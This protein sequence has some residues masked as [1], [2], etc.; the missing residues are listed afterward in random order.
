[1]QVF[2]LVMETKMIHHCNCKDYNGGQC[3]N[4][5]NGAHEFCSAKKICRNKNSK[6]LGLPIVIKQRPMKK[7]II[8]IAITAV[9]FA[10][11]KNTPTTNSSSSSST[12]KTK[13]TYSYQWKSMGNGNIY[14]STEC[15]NDSMI[16]RR[17][18]DMGAYNFVKQS[19]T[20]C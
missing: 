6:Q 16:N 15:M 8:A 13:Y 11:K 14:T 9:L 18:I 3:Y 12:S 19:P 2:I 17:T 5:L 10:C 7:I 1:M 4:C 20:P